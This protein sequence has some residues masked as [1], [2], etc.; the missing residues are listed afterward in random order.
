MPAIQLTEDAQRLLLDYPWPGNVRQ[1]KNVTEQISIIERNREITAEI[2][3]TY[4]PAP[5]RESVCPPW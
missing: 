3:Q 2:L 4:I 5:V 1:L